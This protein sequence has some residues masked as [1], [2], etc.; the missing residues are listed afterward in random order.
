MTFLMVFVIFSGLI[1]ISNGV[2]EGL[3]IADEVAVSNRISID[4]AVESLEDKTGGA[5]GNVYILADQVGVG[6]FG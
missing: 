1:E 5:A 4:F 3:H 2:R 6:S